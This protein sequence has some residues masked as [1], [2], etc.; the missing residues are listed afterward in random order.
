MLS[1]RALICGFDLP[2]LLL[3]PA[4]HGHGVILFFPIPILAQYVIPAVRAIG[5]CRLLRYGPLS[6]LLCS[7]SG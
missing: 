4:L 3:Q 7:A 6:G 1:A 2:L 5:A